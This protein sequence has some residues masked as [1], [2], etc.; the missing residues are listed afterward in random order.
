MTA[1]D[2]E[3][4]IMNEI[5]EQNNGGNKKDGEEPFVPVSEVIEKLHCG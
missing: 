1:N 5:R 4:D 2:Q 3:E